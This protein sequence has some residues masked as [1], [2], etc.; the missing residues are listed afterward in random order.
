LRLN[1]KTNVY[2]FNQ[3][4]QN[5]WTTKLPWAKSVLNEDE[6][7]TLVWCKICKKEW[8]KK[9]FLLPNLIFLVNMLV[10]KDLQISYAWHIPKGWKHTKPTKN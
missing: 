6:F 3:K 1:L 8:V 5:V 7:V 9:N 10:W 2:Q 4:F